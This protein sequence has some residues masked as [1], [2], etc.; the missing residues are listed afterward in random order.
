MKETKTSH[1]GD[2]EE[3]YKEPV[4]KPKSEKGVRNGNAF[5]S[6]NNHKVI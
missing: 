5:G 6:D 1:Y 3:K 2:K 4:K